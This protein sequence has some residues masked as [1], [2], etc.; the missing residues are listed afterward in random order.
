MERF[1]LHICNPFFEEVREGAGTWTT[2]LW[3]QWFKSLVYV[4]T[5][6]T[7]LDF[8]FNDKIFANVL[9]IALLIACGAGCAEKVT[10]HL[11]SVLLNVL[12]EE[13]I[14]FLDYLVRIAGIIRMAGIGF[15]IHRARV[16]ED[17][18]TL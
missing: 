11:S 13:L 2:E 9:K 16:E 7:K 6:R 1:L 14:K 17:T 4:M 3:H 8:V 12:A 10:V 5:L 15:C 18:Y